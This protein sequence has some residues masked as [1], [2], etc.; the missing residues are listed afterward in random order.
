M[1]YGSSAKHATHRTEEIHRKALEN[2][3]KVGRRS[4]SKNS[5]AIGRGHKEKRKKKKK[6]KRFQAIPEPLSKRLSLLR[7]HPKTGDRRVRFLGGVSIALRGREKRSGLTEKKTTVRIIPQ[8]LYLRG[9]AA[10]HTSPSREKNILKEEHQKKRFA[11]I[12]SRKRR[13]QPRETIV[14]G[15]DQKDYAYAFREERKKSEDRVTS[16]EGLRG[17]YR[18]GEKGRK[19]LRSWGGGFIRPGGDARFRQREGGFRMGQILFTGRGTVECL[20]KM[21]EKGTNSLY[22]RKTGTH[23]HQCRR[24]QASHSKAKKDAASDRGALVGRKSGAGDE[25]SRFNKEKG[26]VGV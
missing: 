6:K 24:E 19:G 1:G 3:T 11:S 23:S 22:E 16:R 10:G 21:Q 26:E 2:R 13:T 18:E 20:F 12:L 7:C 15:G 8:T 14:R 25:N 4:C 5:E 9:S 17:V